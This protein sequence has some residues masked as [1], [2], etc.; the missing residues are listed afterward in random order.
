MSRP[1][2]MVVFFS[3][4]Y[5]SIFLFVCRIGEFGDEIEWEKM[6]A[7][8]CTALE[9]VHVHVQCIYNICICMFMYSVL[10]LENYLQTSVPVL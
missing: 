10:R 2:S 8:A 3:T 7:L 1:H 6:L 5:S 4:L 9:K